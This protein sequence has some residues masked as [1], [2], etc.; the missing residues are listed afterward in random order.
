MSN[1]KIA[2]INN[3]NI[4]VGVIV[5]SIDDPIEQISF[6]GLLSNPKSFEVNSSS[7]ISVG[8]KYIDGIEYEP[9]AVV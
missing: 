9:E 2:I 6:S 4:V 5:F 8:W 3:E 7:S 1:K